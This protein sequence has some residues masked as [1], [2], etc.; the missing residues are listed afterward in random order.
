MHTHETA[1]N[2]FIK[3]DGFNYAYRRFGSDDGVPLILLQRFRGTMDEWDP[4]VT[5]GLAKSRP[6]ILFDNAG[7]G[8]SSGETPDSVDA[9]A[10]HVVAFAEA[11]G[12]KQ[13]DLLGFS[14]GGFVAQ[15]VALDRPDLVRRVIL[16]G[17]GPKGGE[18][19]QSFTPEVTEAA[20][21]VPGRAEDV[22]FLFF[23]KSKASQAQGR[24][25]LGRTMAR[26]ADR[27]QQSSVQTMGAQAQAIASWGSAPNGDYEYLRK[28]KQPALLVNGANDIMIPTINSYLMSQHMPNAQLIVYPDS[29]HGALFQYHDRF[30]AEA[31]LFLDS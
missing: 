16:A 21:H 12:L 8:L 25:F 10:R 9:M 6:V 11:L 24:E 27:E 3:A 14:L 5:N 29:G 19:M 18:G 23:A 15:Q 31:G 22:L 30:V 20:T 4:A 17:T 7:V 13:I 26:Q 2:R 1:P 28:I